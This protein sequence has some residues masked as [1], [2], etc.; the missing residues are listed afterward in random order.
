MSSLKYDF[1]LFGKL[2]QPNIVHWLIYNWTGYMNIIRLVSVRQT[3]VIFGKFVDREQ[4][5]K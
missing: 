5:D 1:R 3:F 2:A 4:I